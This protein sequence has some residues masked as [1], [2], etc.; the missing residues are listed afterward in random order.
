MFGFS[1]IVVVFVIFLYS[2]A[3]DSIFFW[4]KETVGNSSCFGKKCWWSAL[5]A[6]EDI[7]QL[8]GMLIFQQCSYLENILY[9]MHLPSFWCFIDLRH[10]SIYTLWLNWSAFV[11][12]FVIYKFYFAFIHW[13]LCVSCGCECRDYP[14]FYQKLYALLEPAIFHVKYRARFFYLLDLFLTST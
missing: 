13:I 7:N 5:L 10:Q 2:I 14:D 6:T 4:Q 12:L 9:W 1:L 8:L 3:S 11:A